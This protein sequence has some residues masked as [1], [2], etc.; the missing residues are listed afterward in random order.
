[1]HRH[2]K[3]KDAQERRQ[4]TMGGASSGMRTVLSYLLGVAV[5]YIA[6]SAASTHFVLNGLA[7]IGAPSSLS[8]RFETTLRDIAGL[9]A[10]AGVIA[11]G[12]LVAFPV[13]A[14]IRRVLSAPRWVAYPLA[15]AAAI[16]AALGLMALQFGM[17]P[18]GG[19]NSAAGFAAQCFA[20]ALGG[21]VFALSVPKRDN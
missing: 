7:E 5:A 21:L 1:M 12:F 8:V 13:G 15:G 9:T 17:T 16:F 19:A 6:A 2:V 4:L 3:P 18:I 10:Y 20:G 14:L 11:I